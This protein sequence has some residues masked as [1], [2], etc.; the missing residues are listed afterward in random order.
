MPQHLDLW[1]LLAGLGIFM[2]G[3]L[4]LEE[5]VRIMSGKAFKRMIRHYTNGRLKSIASGALVTAVLQSSSA[6]SLMVFAFVGAN[7]MSM[8]NAIGVIMGSNMG[9]T[10]TA[11]IVATVGFKI[12]IESFALPLI[13]VGGIGLI[14]FN[15]TSKLFQLSRLL[16][17]FGFLFLGLDYMKGSVESFSQS[18]N[19]SQVPNYGLWF[20]LLIGIFITALMQAS[21]AT[22]AVVLTALN[23]QLITFEIAAVMVIGANVGTTIT[24]LLGAI[25]GTPPKKRVAMSHLLFNVITGAIVFFA[26]PVIIWITSQMIDIKTNSVVALA[27]FHTLFNIFG[28]ILFLPFVGLMSRM[29]EKLFQEEKPVL[30]VYIDKTSPEVMDAAIAALRK[31]VF[32]LYEECQLY[33]LRLLSID[34][35]L[36]FDNDP[37]FA[38]STKRRTTLDE[39]YEKIKLLHAEIFMYYSTL[40]TQKL[41]GSETKEMERIIYAS[42][43]IMNALKNFKGIRLNMDEFD[44]SE[45]KYVNAQYKAFRKRLIKLYHDMSDIMEMENKEVLY[46]KLLATFRQV[47]EADNHYI[48]G[49]MNAVAKK[50][51]HEMEIASLI[52]VNRLFT[53]ALRMQIY[54]IKDL[55]L[56]PEQIKAFDVALDEN[57]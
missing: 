14:L 38:K 19:L 41:E 29:L 22:L 37:L 23:S 48:K 46:D 6:V 7:V 45:N 21:A 1:K 33:N 43:N 55:L 44:N 8:G 28:V 2:F 13:G 50:Q 40:Q 11:W 10:L 26:L 36:V 49:T 31:E 15:N 5:S 54:S 34:E 57:S 42:R 51:L 30:T 32:H 9:T 12:K 56:T 27:L 3:M 4:L 47:D 18:F 17:G 35:K 39:L 24:V 25:S 20:Y 16:I 52:L 53:Q